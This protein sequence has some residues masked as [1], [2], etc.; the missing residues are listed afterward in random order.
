MKIS[1]LSH[2]QAACTSVE[3]SP[4]KL[5]AVCPQSE[6]CDGDKQL[7]VSRCLAKM[8]RIHLLHT[9]SPCAAS[10]KFMFEVTI[11]EWLYKG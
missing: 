8:H 11:T 2:C 7:R 9:V 6:Y 10:T 4:R 1:C 5:Q 3:K